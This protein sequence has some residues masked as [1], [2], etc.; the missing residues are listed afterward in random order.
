MR[1]TDFVGSLYEKKKTVDTFNIKL[2]IIQTIKTSCQAKQQQQKQLQ[3]KIKYV[4]AKRDEICHKIKLFPM[5]KPDFFR[6]CRK[7][8]SIWV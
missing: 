2:P 6:G 1:Y 3:P 5:I 7:I 4:S 8:I